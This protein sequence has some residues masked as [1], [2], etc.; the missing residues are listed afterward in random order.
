MIDIENDTS[1][2]MRKC[3]IYIL[4]C[5]LSTVYTMCHLSTNWLDV[6]SIVKFNLIID[7]WSFL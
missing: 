5:V 1:M 6:N 4:T 2:Q 3:T 7:C